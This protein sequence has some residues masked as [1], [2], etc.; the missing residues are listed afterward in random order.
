MELIRKIKLL[1]KGDV[2][3]VKTK[4]SSMDELVVEQV[5]D[6]LLNCKILVSSRGDELI[7][8]VVDGKDEIEVID[9]DKTRKVIDIKPSS[10][11]ILISDV[12]MGKVAMDRNDGREIQN[13]V[14]INAENI[15]VLGDCPICGC[16]VVRENTKAICTSC[17]KRCSIEQWRAFEDVPSK[18][19]N[20]Q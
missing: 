20:E 13:G 17:N 16:V 6:D 5:E 18:P 11:E 14:E 8:I 4:Q 2:I 1:E 15:D 19:L 12:E 7:E 3:N 9:E 10:E